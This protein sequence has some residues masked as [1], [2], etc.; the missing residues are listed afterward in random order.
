MAGLIFY[1][2]FWVGSY[3]SNLQDYQ[4]E[5]NA[6]SPIDSEII[7]DMSEILAKRIYILAAY[8]ALAS[9]MT[10]S[11]ALKG[12]HPLSTWKPFGLVYGVGF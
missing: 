6:V 12:S 3:A 10:S 7:E 4:Y 9:L 5:L 8:A 1:A 2:V 11:G